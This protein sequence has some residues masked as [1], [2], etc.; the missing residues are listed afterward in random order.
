MASYVLR[1]HKKKKKKAVH[2]SRLEH[3]LE[4]CLRNVYE[5]YSNLQWA[6]LLEKGP[7]SLIEKIMTANRW[8][9]NILIMLSTTCITQIGTKD[10][11][12]QSSMA[13]L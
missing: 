6:R 13:I 2:G 4:H 5:E 1:Q 12:Q 7:L 3:C 10:I 9:K 11:E 8:N